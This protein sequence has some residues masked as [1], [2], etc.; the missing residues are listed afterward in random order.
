MNVWAVKIDEFFYTRTGGIKQKE[1]V[2]K[3]MTAEYNKT[4]RHVI[5]QANTEGSAAGLSVT[6]A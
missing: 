2:R 1:M 4:L 3:I 6:S 5:A